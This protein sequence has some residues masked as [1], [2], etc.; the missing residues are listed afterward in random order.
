MFCDA[1]QWHFPTPREGD[2]FTVIVDL[3]RPLS[4]NGTVKL[5]ST[6]P[7]EQ[8]DIN[9]NFFSNELDLVALREGVRFVDDIIMNG[10]GMRDIIESDF[11]W[12]MP[13]TSDEGMIKMI[14]ERSQTGFRTFPPMSPV[15]SGVLTMNRSLW[16][17]THV[18]EY[19]AGCRRRQA[20]RP[21]R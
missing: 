12:P 6:N 18:P 20:P 1:F 15:R 7:L 9:I 16:Y 2:Y 13:R 19:P 14:L 17:G 10:E 5:N 11:P 8:P 3:L 21:W 4:Q